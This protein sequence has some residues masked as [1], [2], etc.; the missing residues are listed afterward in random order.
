[1]SKERKLDPARDR[2]KNGRLVKKSHLG[3]SKGS[4][5]ARKKVIKGK[6]VMKPPSWHQV[7]N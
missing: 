7:I 2:S 5:E 6:V 1:M 4:S 3:R